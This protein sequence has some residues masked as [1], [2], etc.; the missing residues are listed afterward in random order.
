MVLPCQSPLRKTHDLGMFHKKRKGRD[1]WLISHGSIPLQVEVTML[2]F[3]YLLGM[4]FSR[5]CDFRSVRAGLRVDPRDEV[6]GLDHV[7]HSTD[8][9]SR[10]PTVIQMEL[11]D[12][13]SSC[14]L[15]L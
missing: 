9:R 4:A 13:E 10:K 7:M 14:K 15:G 1:S 8:P 12:S 5:R 6:L 2:P 3:F 11:E